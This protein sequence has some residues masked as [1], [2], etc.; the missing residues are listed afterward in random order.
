MTQFIR[1]LLLLTFT[2]I[3]GCTPKIITMDDATKILLNT[4]QRI[5]AIHYMHPVF[6]LPPYSTSGGVIG[7]VVSEIVDS[8]RGERIEEKF[9]LYDPILGVKED[10]VSTILNT[11]PRLK[12]SNISAP[13]ENDDVHD[14]KG[15]FLKG[16]ILDFQTRQWGIIRHAEGW[17]YLKPPGFQ[18]R[19][20]VTLVARARLIDPR[21]ETIL[22]QGICDVEDLNN[23]F[24]MEDVENWHNGTNNNLENL[25]NILTSMCVK[26]LGEQFI[27]TQS[28]VQ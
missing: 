21:E 10:F 11:F 18:E 15:Q 9:G 25:F 8:A 12:F 23:I 26:E 3:V 28:F 4:T 22:W 2:V 16:Y 5:T 17:E 7:G 13:F 24:T 1:I 14:L 19:R 20:K 6:K 27:K